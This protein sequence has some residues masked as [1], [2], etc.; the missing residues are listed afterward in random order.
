[1]GLRN[2]HL[3]LPLQRFHLRMSQV[4]FGRADRLRVGVP[5]EPKMLA[6]HLP[7]VTYHQVYY[8]T[9]ISRSLPLS[10]QHL[11]W[12]QSVWPCQLGATGLLS[13]SKWHFS[14][15]TQHVNL[16]NTQ[17]VN[18][19]IVWGRQSRDTGG[20]HEHSLAPSPRKVLR[21]GITGI[22]WGD[23]GSFVEPSVNFGSGFLLEH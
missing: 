1:M 9:K 19:R 16:R 8:F 20:A 7:R 4:S 2:T 10:S 14:P 22:V 23:L 15:H 11:A 5:R 13:A 6:R 17:H 21:G 12:S 3:S 18:L